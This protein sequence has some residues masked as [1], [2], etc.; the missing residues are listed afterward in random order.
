M[1]PG[2]ADLSGA[3]FRLDLRQSHDEYLP[4]ILSEVSY[5][6]IED[7]AA[8]MS[9]ARRNLM[10]LHENIQNV[11]LDLQKTE[12]EAGEHINALLSNARPNLET[13]QVMVADNVS[14]ITMVQ[15]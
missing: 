5:G 9:R 4:E 12:F 6:Y 1:E 3:N 11:T 8:L 7:R 15:L 13:I 10:D 2:H 14:I